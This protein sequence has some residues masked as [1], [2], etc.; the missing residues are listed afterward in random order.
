CRAPAHGERVIAGVETLIEHASRNLR[1]SFG[2]PGGMEADLF[3]LPAPSSDPLRRTRTFGFFVLACAITW[4]LAAPTAVAWMRHAAPAPFALA[5]AGLSAFGP[6]LAALCFSFRRE[7]RANLFRRFS[8]RPALI[9]LALAAP[10]AIHLIA[11]ALYA[12]FGGQPSAWLHP[13]T[14]PEQIAALVVFPLG[15]E[16]G[17]RGFAHPRLVAR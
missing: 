7:D 11:T 10:F 16:F 1:R 3:R 6:L 8:A 9:A 17:W 13:P 4:L 12:A 14:R 15:E 5:C 2:V